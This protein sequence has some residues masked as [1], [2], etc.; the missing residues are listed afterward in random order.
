M[1][2]PEAVLELG[3]LQATL[4]KDPHDPDHTEWYK[5]VVPPEILINEISCSAAVATKEYHTSSSSVPLHSPSFSPD[6]VAPTTVPGLT[7][8]QRRSELTVR[9][10]APLH[11]SLA[12][13]RATLFFLDKL[14]HTSKL[15]PLSPGDK[16]KGKEGRFPMLTGPETFSR[17]HHC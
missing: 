13:G 5:S 16:V 12:G 7:V 10:T 8:V 9:D 17:C 1:L 4:L 6:P 2:S 14:I 15:S 11:S 3:S